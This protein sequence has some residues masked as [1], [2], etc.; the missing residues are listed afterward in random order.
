[1]SEPERFLSL[2]EVA[3]LLGITT[4]GLA[5]QKLTQPDVMIGSTRG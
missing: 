5:S 1:M 4:G 2:S 3:A